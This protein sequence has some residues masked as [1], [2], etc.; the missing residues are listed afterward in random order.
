[1]KTFDIYLP[2]SSY[3]KDGKLDAFGE[4]HIKLDNYIF[5]SEVW[6]DFGLYTVSAWAES[7][8]QLCDKK[9]KKVQCK[10]MDGNYRFDISAKD[11]ENWNFQF[12]AERETDEIWQEGVV[13]SEQ[14]IKTLLS[15]ID[16]ILEEEQKESSIEKI[17]FWQEARQKLAEAQKFED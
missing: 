11:S 6:T 9:T 14:A 16:I 10:F 1:M 13:N 5:P 3:K 12:I 17:T 7:F 15:T 2:I 8:I 4:I